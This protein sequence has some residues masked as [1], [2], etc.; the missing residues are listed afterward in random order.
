MLLHLAVVSASN[1][2]MRTDGSLAATLV[3]EAVGDDP[4]RC[5]DGLAHLIFDSETTAFEVLI[6]ELG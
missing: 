2:P 6:W 5:L 1:A 4:Q 3:K